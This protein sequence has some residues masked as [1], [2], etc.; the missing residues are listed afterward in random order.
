MTPSEEKT[1]LRR[2]KNGLEYNHFIILF[3]KPV[4]AF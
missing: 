4:I 1:K 3:K 2:R